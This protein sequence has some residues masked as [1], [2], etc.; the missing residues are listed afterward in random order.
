MEANA[1]F[2]DK[3]IERLRKTA[4]DLEALQIQLT[5]GK[6][7]A[8]DK[9]EEFKKEFSKTLREIGS[10]IEKSNVQ[11][12]SELKVLLEEL[13]VQ[14]A[15]GKAEARDAF[16]EQKK[17]IEKVLQQIEQKINIEPLSNE[18]IEKLNDEI[19]RFR[20]I[21]EILRVKYE[22]GKYETRDIY[23]ARKKEFEQKIN[24]LKQ[25]INL[26]A[27]TFDKQAS[28]FKTEIADA[29]AHLKKAFGN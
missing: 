13:Q 27:E 15:L 11:G 28:I 12:A 25:K 23:E 17:K 10:T 9:Y 19:R 16:L 26:K 7:E 3:V 29:Y 21:L 24:S 6:A 14:L 1:T 5:L 22:L 4:T 8:R 20:I 2:T 18:I